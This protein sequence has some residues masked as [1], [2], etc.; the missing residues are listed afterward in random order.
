MSVKCAVCPHGCELADNATGRCR[1]RRNI[2]GT[3]TAVNYGQI[4]SMALD[5]IEKKPLRHF[6]PGSK[7]LSVGSYGC[8]LR[9]GFC[10]NYRISMSGEGA[11]AATCI[12]PAELAERAEAAVS[13]GNIGVAYTYNE[14][15][16][17]YEY[18]CDATK[19]VRRRG[20]YNV[21]V[22]NGYVC[23]EPLRKLLPSIDAM[24]IDLKGFTPNFYRELGGDLATVKETIRR[25]H[26]AVHVEITTLIIP[27]KNDSD[28]EI[29]TM[30]RWLA[31]IDPQMPWHISRFFP[32]YQYDKGKPTPTETV[33]RLVGVAQEYLRHVYP[34][35]CQ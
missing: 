20:L 26:E 3:V 17:G 19:A 5:P 35:N 34:G 8:N 4:T 6:Y 10:Q 13:N 21:L 16:I 11:V 15:L 2:G 27:G 33:Y 9:C 18:L 25:A 31:A 30:A 12:S 29:R 14:P 23:E 22:T 32:R 7:I 24:N 28:E 1:A